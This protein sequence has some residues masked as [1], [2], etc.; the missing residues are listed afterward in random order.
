MHRVLLAAVTGLAVMASACSATSTTAALGDQPVLGEDG[1]Y[2]VPLA[3]PLPKPEMV[4]TDTNG[5]PFDFRSETAGKPTLLF[6]GYASCPDICPVH[7]SVIAQAM[8]EVRIS[9]DALSVVF[10]STDPDRDTPEVMKA[11]LDAFDPGFIGLTG[12]IDQITEAMGE[13]NLPAPTYA[14]PD[15]NGFYIVGHPAT[16]VAFDADGMARHLYPFG[17]R[18]AQWVNDLPQ[19]MEEAA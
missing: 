16:I 7:L 2:G 12:D 18:R 4:L 15:E 19:L 11:Y 3:E 5:E 1:R 14:E 9:S 13:L 6:F 10:V 17:M 8:D